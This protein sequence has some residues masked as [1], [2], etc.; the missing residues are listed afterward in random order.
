MGERGGKLAELVGMGGM[1]GVRTLRKDLLTS[2]SSSQGVGSPV[3]SQEG[4]RE[5]ST[6]E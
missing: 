3:S 4:W 5:P 1:V 6:P 2:P